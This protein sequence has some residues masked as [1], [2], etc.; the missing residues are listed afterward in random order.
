MSKDKQNYENLKNYFLKKKDAPKKEQ[1]KT[2]GISETDL[3]EAF[4]AGKELVQNLSKK[5]NLG[6][7]M[8]RGA[9]PAG[10]LGAGLMGYHGATS[11]DEPGEQQQAVKDINDYFA[12]QSANLQND[13]TSSQAESRQ[14]IQ[15][16][17]E[18]ERDIYNQ[19]R[20]LP[21]QRQQEMVSL[22]DA[23]NNPT[24]HTLQQGMKG[25]AGGA[26]I[27][28]SVPLAQKVLQLAKLI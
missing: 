18:Q 12:T 28:A 24:M 3:Q 23:V 14:I 9:I 21:M 25:L 10:L 1:M 27:G 7:M 2:A 6:Q 15:Q 16:L 22:A 5:A 17:A 4:E 20:N 11:L 8:M 13:L 19:L 26:A